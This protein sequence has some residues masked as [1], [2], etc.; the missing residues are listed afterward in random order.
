V[1]RQNGI[2]PTIAVA[3]FS[4]AYP[5]L[6][7]AKKLAR[8]SLKDTYLT[9]DFRFKKK[10]EKKMATIKGWSLPLIHLRLSPTPPA[11]ELQHSGLAL[12]PATPPTSR[13]LPTL[14]LAPPLPAPWPMAVRGD[15]SPVPPCHHER[16][17]QKTKKPPLQLCS[18]RLPPVVVMDFLPR[19][20]F[21][22]EW[23]VEGA[24]AWVVIGGIE[25][26][27]LYFLQVSCHD[28]FRDID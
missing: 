15:R 2:A 6:P 8:M 1:V 16:G 18:F 27:F 11:T 20:E 25:G 22:V 13:R 5:Y 4:R 23:F 3:P 9:F 17:G 14:G 19:V 21:R 10:K 12:P 7:I 28:G 26:H 24:I